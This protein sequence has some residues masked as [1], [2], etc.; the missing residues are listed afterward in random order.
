R[1]AV[2]KHSPRAE[3]ATGPGPGRPGG[4]AKPDWGQ[5]VLPPLGFPGAPRPGSN[6]AGSPPRTH[7]YAARHSNACAEIPLE[8][9]KFALG[10]TPSP[11]PRPTAYPAGQI[12]EGDRGGTIVRTESVEPSSTV[13]NHRWEN[14]ASTAAD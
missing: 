8:A 12:V 11:T 4:E 1:P 3:R 2:P 9:D 5:L 10:L 14:L 6:G 13:P 7:R